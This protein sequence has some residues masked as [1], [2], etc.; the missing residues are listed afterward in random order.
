MYVLT[1]RVSFPRGQAVTSLPIKSHLL[2]LASVLAGRAQVVFLFSKTIHK[3]FQKAFACGDIS[4]D[5]NNFSP[6]E[7]QYF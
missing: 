2:A 4:F 6:I 7:N 3:H 1:I 5:R